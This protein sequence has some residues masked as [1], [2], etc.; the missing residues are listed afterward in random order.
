MTSDTVSLRYVRHLVINAYESC[1][2]VRTIQIFITCF[3]RL[4]VLKRQECLLI[5]EFWQAAST[6]FTVVVKWLG[7]MSFM[8]DDRHFLANSDIERKMWYVVKGYFWY[9]FKSSLSQT[10]C[11]TKRKV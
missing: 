7:A 5:E 10:V 1:R 6:G 4:L 9:H 2:T 8:P 11:E 3:K